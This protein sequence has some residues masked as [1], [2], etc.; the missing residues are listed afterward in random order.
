MII[1]LQMDPIESINVSTDTSFMIGLE[2]QRRGFQLFCY[3]PH[4]LSLSLEG[5]KAYGHFI[6]LYDNPDHYFEKQ[7]PVLFDLKQADIVW[8]RQDPPF[9][10]AYITATYLLDT[11]ASTTLVLN[12]PKSIRDYPEKLLPFQFQ[13][14]MA[15]TLISRNIED[16]YNFFETHQDVVLKPLYGAKGHAVIRLKDK[17][18]LGGAVDLFQA[19]ENTPF[20]MQKFIPEVSLGDKR[21]LFVDGDVV[22]AFKRIPQTGYI[23]SNIALGGTAELCDLTLKEQK[24]AK[25]LGPFLKEK[26]LFLAGI[27]VIGDYLTEINITSPTGYVLLNRLNNQK[28]HEIIW[29]KALE[30]L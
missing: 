28:T 16:F 11:I 1:A 4:N 21:I 12:N 8:V 25:V 24:L 19:L 29:D 3:H 30:K 18:N 5:L 6:K 15:P 20:I 17:E 9:D 10:L 14:F 13:E 22:G 26:G 7:D 2:A 23:R 27:D